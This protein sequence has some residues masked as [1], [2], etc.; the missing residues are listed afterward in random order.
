MSIA[1]YA[2]M[3]PPSH[4]TPSG[5]R[6]MARLLMQA[7]DRA[8]YSVFLAS[9]W[10]TR[11]G[12]GNPQTQKDM[13]AF[14][15]QETKRV[16]TVTRPKLWFTYHCYYKAPDLI[17]PRVSEA[18]GIPYIIAEASRAKKRLGGP[19]DDFAKAAE[20]AIDTADILFAMT[21]HDRFALDRDRFGGQ[22]IVD[23]PPFTDL[24]AIGTRLSKAKSERLQLLAVAMMR[25]GAKME[26]YRRLA[27]SLPHIRRDFDLTI[28]GDGPTRDEVED[29]F[30]NAT[31]LGALEADD[32]QAQYAA[33]DIFVWPGVEEAYGMVY[34]EAQANGVP[35][36]A[37]D[38]PG[39]RSVVASALVPTNNPAAFAAAID[40]R[41]ED[42]S[43]YVLKNH[44]IDRAAA[45]LRETIGP[46]S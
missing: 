31:F 18:L 43:D 12:K 16:M 14:A 21:A 41:H 39:P 45:I 30:P 6:R 42:P 23:F 34:L 29:L 32:V 25:P 17:G 46:L 44:S 35:V 24:A 28:V 20:T 3:K 15:P 26:S 36:V 19:W 2:P 9:N 38:H 4:P 33:A 10:R 40:G 22:K 5:D 1:F 37:E 11:D 13:L 8:G 7:L 27:A